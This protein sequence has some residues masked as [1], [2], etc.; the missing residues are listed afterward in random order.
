MNGRNFVGLVFGLCLAL[1]PA[2]ALAA[3]G[4]PVVTLPEPRASTG[5]NASSTIASTNTFQS[6]WAANAV[7][8][9][10]TIENNGT[11]TMWVFFGPI[12]SATEATSVQLAAGQSVNCDSAHVVSTDQVSIT[13]TS[14]DTFFAQQQ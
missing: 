14:G 10:C 2:M 12:A 1:A 3:A 13:G 4:Q 11:N 7:R 6:L 8:G 9:S 5:G